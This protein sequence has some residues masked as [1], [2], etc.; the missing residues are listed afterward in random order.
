MSTEKTSESFLS[1]LKKYSEDER[2]KV[3][4]EAEE[5][6]ERELKEARQNAELEAEAYVTA[7]VSKAKAQITGEYAVKNL[8]SQGELFKLRAGLTEDV[9]SQARKR[10][11]D[12]T[13]TEP[14][15]ALL[16]KLTCEIRQAFS[17]APCVLFVKPE[18]MKFTKPIIKAYGKA[19]LKAD[20]AI[21][22]GGIR[23]ICE[24]L[25]IEADNTLDR[26]LAEERRKFT[27]KAELIID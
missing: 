19:E 15:S 24:S 20:A 13:S 9:F 11:L 14:Y 21:E 27:E 23:G 25:N 18:D 17:G 5:K 3:R 10:I 8:D 16:V 12:F 2:E 4:T 26:R 6:A 7:Q 22:L 1:A